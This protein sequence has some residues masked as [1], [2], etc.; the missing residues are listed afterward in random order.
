MI[1]DDSWSTVGSANFDNR[2]LRINEEA[3]L[4]VLDRQFATEL[5]AVFENDRSRSKEITLAAW[6]ARSISEKMIG[7]A[8]N[9][10]RSQM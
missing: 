5:A 10:L 6:R 4:N 3:N 1:I 9:L 8:G 7:C 2:S